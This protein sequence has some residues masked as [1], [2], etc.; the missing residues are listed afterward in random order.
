MDLATQRDQILAHLRDGNSLT[1]LE[2]LRRFGCFRLGARIWDLK[3]DG[4]DIRTELVDVNGKRV[5][6]YRMV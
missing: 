1:P 5:A 4:H 6:K 3:Q 2:A